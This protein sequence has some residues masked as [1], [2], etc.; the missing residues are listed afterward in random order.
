MYL[1]N[2]INNKCFE[3]FTSMAEFI[4]WVTKNAENNKVQTW[5]RQIKKVRKLPYTHTP[6]KCLT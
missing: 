3:L 6:R 2:Q 5:F 1:K 4:L